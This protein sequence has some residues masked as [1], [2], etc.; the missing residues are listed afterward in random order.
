MAPAPASGAAR[1]AIKL[2][3]DGRDQ[4]TSVADPRQL[5]TT[6]TV[7]GYGQSRQQ[8]SLT[9]NPA[10]AGGVTDGGTRIALL[11]Q[12]GYAPFGA[13]RSWTW[14]NHSA[15][16]PNLYARLFNL[17]GRLVAYP[18][19]NAAHNGLQRIVRYD[20]AGRIA[21]FEHT[22]SASA[23]PAPASFDQRFGYDN[24]DRLTSFSSNTGTQG[25]GYDASGNRSTLSYGAAS[26]NYVTSPASNRLDS[27]SGPLP[28]K[29]YDYDEAGNLIRELNTTYTYRDFGQRGQ[30]WRSAT[31]KPN[32]DYN[33]LGQRISKRS[34]LLAG[35]ANVYA[36]DEAGHLLGEYDAAGVA[37][38]ETVYLGD[39]PVAVLKPGAPSAPNIY[40]VYADQINTARVITSAAGNAMVWRWDAADPFGVSHPLENPGG[41]AAFVYNPRFPGQLFDFETNTHYNYYR[42]YDPQTGRYVQSDP[43]GLEGGINTYGYVGGN[44]L[45]KIDPLG[46]QAEGDLSSPRPG[47]LPGPFDVLFPGTKANNDFVSSAWKLIKGAKSSQSNLEACEADCDADF[48]ADQKTCEWQWKMRGRNADDYRVCISMA[49]T[50]HVTCYQKCAKEC[51]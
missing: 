8:T 12:I 33:G 11:N 30:M 27:T 35:G 47:R 43:I 7:D 48:D 50:K 46:L 42:D 18:L 5:L 28:A 16:S 36:Y 3:Y 23:S 32:Y 2:G 45:S 20:A 38:E 44:P 4:L 39:L 41:G 17:D 34:P 1:P 14:G 49:T 19:G 31:D 9:L 6:Y 22:G 26:Y 13:P 10:G 21:A 29:R 40:Y 51:K 15:A 25:Y 37:L 24:L